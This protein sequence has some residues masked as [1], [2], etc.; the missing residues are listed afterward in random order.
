MRKAAFLLS[1]IFICAIVPG[2]SNGLIVEST[3]WESIEFPVKYENLPVWYYSSSPNNFYVNDSNGLRAALDIAR[4]DG[5]DNIIYLESGTYAALGPFVYGGAGTDNN[6]V[7][8]SGGG[9][10]FDY[11]YDYDYDYYNPRSTNPEDTKIDGNSLNPV[12]QLLADA[13]DVNFSFKIENLTI[14]NGYTN[15]GDPCGAGIEAYTGTAGQ[16]DIHLEIKN[17]VFRNNT[18]ANGAS[19]GA[20]YCNSSLEI[21]DCNFLSNSAYDGGA[22][23]ITHDPDANQSVAPVIRNCY[24]EGN[25]NDGNQGSTIWHNVALQVSNCVFKGRSGGAKSSGP[26]STIWGDPGSHLNIKNSTFSGIRV[27]GWGS[28]IQSFN[29]AMDITNCLF[30]N[31]YAGI[32]G[33]VAYCH[34]YDTGIIQTINITNCTFTVNTSRGYYGAVSNRGGA[35]IL[36]N[37]I[38]WDNGGYT[39]IDNSYSRISKGGGVIY[40]DGVMYMRHCIHYDEYDRFGNITNGG[41]NSHDNPMFTDDNS[42]HLKHLSPCIDAGNNYLVPAGITTDL[43]GKPRFQDD[44]YTTNT[45]IGSG[46]IVDIGAY[47]YQRTARFGKADGKKTVKLTLK[48]KSNN[49]VTFSLSGSGYGVMDP[50]DPSFSLIEIYNYKDNA[51]PSA[52]SIS[53]KAP[54]GSSAGSIKCY[55]PLKSITAKNITLKGDL[56]I[57]SS[58]KHKAAAAITFGVGEDLNIISKMPIKSIA[59]TEWY[60]SLTAP[61]VGSITTK[62][63]PQ[64]EK[65]GNLIIDAN[66]G[67]DVGSLNVANWLEGTWLCNSVKNITAPGTYNFNLLLSQKPSPDNYALGKLSVRYLCINSRIV[68]A[69]N[70]STVALGKMEN[71]NCFAGVSSISD[72]QGYGGVPDGVFDLPDLSTTTFNGAVIKNVKITGIKNYDPNFFINSNIAAE[73]INNAYVAYPQYHND[74]IPFG[75][76]TAYG[77][78]SLKIKDQWETRSWKNLNQPVISQSRDMQVRRY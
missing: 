73:K 22:L 38:F 2:Q 60:G 21:S 6:S 18:A 27:D 54:D 57:A 69:G 41:Y 45:G 39:G 7:T 67:G 68:S 74:G 15:S 43:A 5:Y 56:T 66:I 35:M 12:L 42:Y 52:F 34:A 11:N 70:I 44:P 76:T 25:F 23:F 16:G 71:S 31:N 59:T 61:S 78:N 1:V 50:C 37:S 46:P 9:S 36:T 47:E 30:A 10:Y 17:C 48:D 49:D 8:L 20:I 77:F 75:F 19:G 28:A 33:A 58:A 53:T 40:I 13:Q 24:F 55:C 14:Q 65:W 62:G 64:A 29:G 3:N 72:I 51:S 26:G 63:N 4:T 32:S